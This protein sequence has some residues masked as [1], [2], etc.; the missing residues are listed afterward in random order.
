M[1]ALRADDVVAMDDLP[2]HTTRGVVAAGEAADAGVRQLP[3]YSP[4]LDPIELAFSKFKTSST[5]TEICDYR[6]APAPP[7]NVLDEIECRNRLGH[8]GYRY[9]GQTTAGRSRIPNDDHDRLRLCTLHKAA[10]ISSIAATAGSGT[11]AVVASDAGANCSFQIARSAPS[12]A[13]SSLASP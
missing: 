4:D 1:K 10:A 13:P 7:W 2:S 3:P 11:V 8:C 6:R 12:T 9:G 5:A